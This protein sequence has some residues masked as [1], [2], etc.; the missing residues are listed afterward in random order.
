MGASLGQK[1]TS[2]E[3]IPPG[4]YRQQKDSPVVQT[5]SPLLLSMLESLFL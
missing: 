5:L 3:C 2:E 4:Q 1:K